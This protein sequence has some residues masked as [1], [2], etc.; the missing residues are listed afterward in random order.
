M[1]IKNVHK[2]ITAYPI[3]CATQKRTNKQGP[4]DP[5]HLVKINEILRPLHQYKEMFR[6]YQ[7]TQEKRYVKVIKSWDL[8]WA[9][10]AAKKKTTSVMLENINHASK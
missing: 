3:Q 8:L 1:R 2:Q 10:T 9:Y 4:W 6:V 7:T 5:S